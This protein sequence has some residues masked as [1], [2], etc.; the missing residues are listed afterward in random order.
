MIRHKRSKWLG[1]VW[2]LALAC[3][4]PAALRYEE[5][6]DH[7][8]ESAAHAVH[9]QRLKELMESINQLRNQR[10]P[11]SLDIA[12]EKERQE[13]A[14]SE[15]ARAM[16]DSAARIPEAIP[17]ELDARERSE[18][19]RLASALQRQT[20]NLVEQASALTPERRRVRLGEIDLICGDC[21]RRFRIPGLDDA[22]P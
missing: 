19:L 4:R 10:L 14:F 3:S 11:R 2:L 7:A 5:Q 18:F 15:V 1:I 8:P 16:A 20:S 17:T 21:H 22:S 12:I 13:R 6:L 9:E